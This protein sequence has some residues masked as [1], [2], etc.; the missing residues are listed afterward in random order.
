M[1]AVIVLVSLTARQCTLDNVLL[2]GRARQQNTS[3]ERHVRDRSRE[4]RSRSYSPPSPPLPDITVPFYML[5]RSDEPELTIPPTSRP[6]LVSYPHLTTAARLPPVSYPLPQTN[7]STIPPLIS[8]PTPA[9]KLDNSSAQSETSMAPG[10][11]VGVTHA[12][13]YQQLPYQPPPSHTS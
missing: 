11:G 4:R 5:P 10:N 6:Q 9:Q 13:Q 3:T 12:E 8:Y 2:Q 7:N 1:Y